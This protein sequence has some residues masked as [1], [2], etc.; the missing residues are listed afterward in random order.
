MDTVAK[1]TTFPQPR[2]FLADTPV[3]LESVLDQVPT[4]IFCA[5][6]KGSLLFLNDAFLRAFGYCRAEIGSVGDWWRLAFP[7]A[8]NRRR[9]RSNWL[10][11]MARTIAVGTIAPPVET[12]I[13]CKDGSTRDVDVHLTILANPREHLDNPGER[14]AICIV[15]L[16]DTTATKAALREAEAARAEA[17]SESRAKSAFLANMSH[18]F[19]TPLN[20]IIG[21]SELMLLETHGPLG[22]PVYREYVG[23]ILASGQLLHEVV[24]EILDLAK[25]EAGAIKIKAEPL[26]LY[27]LLAECGR[28]IAP[29]AAKGGIN[30]EF[31]VPSAIAVLADHV[32]LKRI[33]LNLLSNAVKF[34]PPGGRI[35]L[36]AAPDHDNMVNICV[37]DTG[38]GMSESDIE[39]ALKPFG[40]ADIS[41]TR[42]D[43]GTGLGVPIAKNLVELHSGTFKIDSAPGK[44]TKICITL[45]EAAARSAG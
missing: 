45:P 11:V 23:D 36:R 31:E 5:D 7:E 15:T 29:A 35:L 20:A 14:N 27:D 13:R 18:E 33:I 16:A 17:E 26:N 28:V 2:P 41:V 8:E 21:F 1:S 38:I 44:G 9:V 43:K 4:P 37:E 40:Q 19:R 12:S 30:V 42:R 34:T 6:E 39:T 3:S 32:L 25:A 10:E 24:G 22:D